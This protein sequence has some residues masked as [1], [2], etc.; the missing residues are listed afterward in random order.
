LDIIK[1]VQFTHPIIKGGVN[2]EKI[3][4]SIA[5]AIVLILASNTST[6][7]QAQEYVPTQIEDGVPSY[8]KWGQLAVKETKSRYPNAKVIDYLHIGKETKS[9][10]TTLE[11]FKLWLKEDKREFGVFI[12]I[13]YNTETDEL[14][15]ISFEETDK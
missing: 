3:C 2:M 11:K 4:L 14:I 5:I 9:E 7:V 12:D 10:T 13:E 8:A 15:N 6:F 1:F